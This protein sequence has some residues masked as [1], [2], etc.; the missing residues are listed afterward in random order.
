[1]RAEQQVT[2]GTPPNWSKD[3]ADQANK[4]WVEF[5][6]WADEAGVPIP[7]REALLR[8]MLASIEGRRTAQILQA[9]IPALRGPQQ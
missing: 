6:K 1:M 4:R 2:T 7:F 3:M 9:Y 8:D 5:W